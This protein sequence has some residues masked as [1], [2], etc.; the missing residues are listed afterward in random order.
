MKKMLL[1]LVMAA[2]SITACKKDYPDHVNAITSIVGNWR[3]S[4]DL[5]IYYNNGTEA[6]R[7]TNA[8]APSGSYYY[9]F[10]DNSAM[11]LYTYNTTTA[12]YT[13][14][15]NYTYS[16][17]GVNLT[18]KAGSTSTTNRFD[19]KGENNMSFTQNYSGNITYTDAANTTHTAD[20]Y[21]VIHTYTKF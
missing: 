14:T 3:A 4:E 17:D 13:Q 21:T 7:K 9:A 20:S 15:A 11:S 10:Q 18:Y 8:V 1:V 6:Y 2:L 19:F 16:I 12:N 5:T